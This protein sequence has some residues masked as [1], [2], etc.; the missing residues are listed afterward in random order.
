M[1]ANRL[2]TLFGKFI[3]S[4][5]TDSE[6]RELMAFVADRQNEALVKQVMDVYIAEIKTT[7][8]LDAEKANAIL[9]RIQGAGESI[10][11]ARNIFSLR[12]GVWAAAAVF[13][14][15]IA[16]FAV[17]K[18]FQPQIP[19]QQEMGDNGPAAKKAAQHAMLSMSDGSSILLDSI[20][21]DKIVKGNLRIEKKNG[22]LIFSVAG[23][24]GTSAGPV[25]ENTLTTPAGLQYQVLL[26]D[27]TKVWLNAASSLHF[28]GTFTGNKREVS[29]EG[30]GYFEVAHDAGKPFFV[31][32]GDMTVRVLG[33]HF[34]IN[35]YKDD[36]SIRTSLVE[37]SIQVSN[38]NST[39]L[40]VPG[41]QGV[42]RSDDGKLDVQPA[43]I[44]QV[45]AWKEGLFYFSGSDLY[46]IMNQ[47]GRWYNVEIEYEGEIPK[48]NFEGKISRSAQL[49]EILK[50][51][52]LQNF[53]FEV[54]EKKVIVKG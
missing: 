46:T 36:G 15:A 40:L 41:Q 20:G 49:P 11:P 29:L 18:G 47:I 31:K 9:E 32:T 4:E 34:N 51:L 7:A 54:K 19:Q 16:G 33:T 12:S 38:G 22:T 37:G 45:I 30:E 53:R 10:K 44:E 5:C 42:L 26:Q 25:I 21:N 43:D 24:T 39:R 14:L 17:W 23:N 27:G 3:R 50:I 28:P 35:A 48:R 6:K 13:F 2:Q 8:E 1:D 52:E